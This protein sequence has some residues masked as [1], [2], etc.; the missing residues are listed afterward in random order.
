ML[1]YFLGFHAHC[2]KKSATD[3][4]FHIKND[5]LHTKR[6]I[7]YIGCFSVKLSSNMH[8][9][10][11]LPLCDVIVAFINTTTKEPNSVI[12]STHGAY[13]PENLTA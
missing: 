10:V 12:P 9:R 8:L 5:E 6:F 13:I 1:I 2:V 4:I 11:R 3:T 7:K